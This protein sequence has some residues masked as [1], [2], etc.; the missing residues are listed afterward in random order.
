MSDA[1]VRAVADAMQWADLGLALVILGLALWVLWRWRRSWALLVGLVLVMVHGVA[2]HVAT[3]TNAVPAPWTSL[4]SAS[5]RAHIYLFILAS[6]WAG[7]A[8]A[9]SPEWKRG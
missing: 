1:T 7:I 6:L 2:F 9:R 8:A 4:W 5:L 3:L